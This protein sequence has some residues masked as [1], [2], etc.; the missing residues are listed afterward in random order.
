MKAILRTT[1]G[2][3][4]LAFAA[5]PSMASGVVDGPRIH[6]DYALWGKSRAV[7]RYLDNLE[8]WLP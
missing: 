1:I 7:T 2:A 8:K 4:A 6:W 5:S 3:V